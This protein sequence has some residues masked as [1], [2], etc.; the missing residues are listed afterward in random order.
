MKVGLVNP[1]HT[2]KA[3]PRNT[4][5]VHLPGMAYVGAELKREG[6]EIKVVDFMNDRNASLDQV[7]DCRV[8][9]IATYLNSYDFLKNALPQL[10]GEVNGAERIIV[11]GGPL[12][13]SYGLSDKNLLMKE[14]P[15]IHS[16]LIGEGEVL[17]AEFI[18]RGGNPGYGTINRDCLDPQKLYASQEN[19]WLMYN[20]LDD[21]P[22]VDY[23]DWQGFKENVRGKS[24]NFMFSRG[25]SNNPSC[26]FCF[27]Y[28]KGLRTYSLPRI[29]SELERITT[30]LQ[31]RMICVGDDVFAFN[32][33]R[34]YALADLLGTTQL[35]WQIES[36]VNEMTP[37]LA[38]YLARHGCEQIKF[39]VESFSQEVL[40]KV[41]K[42]VTI[43]QIKDAA[44]M[45][46]DA[47]MEASAFILFGLPGETRKSIEET[48]DG[49]RETGYEPRA[50][51]LIP[52]PG[53]QIYKQAVER[54]LVDELQLL[55]DFSKPEN[56][57]TTEGNWVPINLTEVSDAELVDARD[58]ANA[59]RRR[60]A[61]G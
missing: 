50:R 60:Y 42:K 14:F 47:G 30:E 12:V 20:N 27:K 9:G 41:G 35:P 23:N 16:A 6:R 19:T 21:L 34:A 56:F 55:K 3:D 49:I 22:E 40:D 57:D 52:L 59:M 15:Q 31:P 46:Q 54:G 28:Q 61:G 43:Q 10:V 5:L 33:Q 38:Q 51:V 53:T 4:D 48:L 37:E 44:K 2:Y 32:K 11:A 8:V 26:S 45:T 18:H 25:C 24:I 29:E 13:S 1:G 36:R 17:F 7:Q 39:G 58:R